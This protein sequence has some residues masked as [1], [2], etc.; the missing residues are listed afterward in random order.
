MDR[1]TQDAALPDTVRAPRFHRNAHGYGMVHIGVGAFH[2]AHQAPA[3][4]DALEE[5]GGDWRT[6]GVSLRR[7]HVADALN[8]QDGLYTLL[9]R[10]GDAPPRVIGNLGPVLGP[11]HSA[12]DAIL[13]AMTAPATRVVTVTVTEKGYGLDRQTGAPDATDPAVAADLAAAAAGALEAPK[14][15]PGLI[16]AALIIRRAK[17]LR[18]FTT[19]SCDNLPHNGNVLKSLVLG[20]APEAEKAA[21]EA[22]AFPSS[23]VDRITPAATPKTLSDAVAAL[24]L[25]DRAAI[26]TEPFTQWVIED[27]FPEGRPAW[28]AGGALF[29]SDVAPHEAMKLRMLNGA[30]SLIAYL[31]QLH[32][33]ELV[34]H[35]TAVPQH[36]AAVA[37]HMAA[38]AAT[39]PPV[40]GVDLDDYA[41]ALLARFDNPAIAHKTRQIAMDGTQKLGPRIFLPALD[42]VKKGTETAP[43]A[44]V[45]GLWMA[46]ALRAAKD[47][48]L[49]DPEAKAIADAGRSDDPMDA[50]AKAASMPPDL[51]THAPFWQ[52]VEA[53][54]RQG[55][56]KSQGSS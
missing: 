45:V 42:A 43:F 2:R 6:I 7:P 38:A 51:R 41:A 16:A 15:L 29:V 19:L 1:L 55:S 47:G 54:W 13:A 30:H 56:A 12:N 26:E 44:R 28:E 18:P 31:G 17:G 4:D 27:H 46:Y 35:V 49:D 50:L 22:C 37:A 33:L 10:G 8:P 23:M 11:L 25:E 40:P 24:G 32:G 39:L 14:S 52:S 34:R 3:T 21:L 20:V 48:T 36:R 9:T 5:E 53:A